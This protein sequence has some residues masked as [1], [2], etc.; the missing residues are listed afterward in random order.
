MSLKEKLDAIAAGFAA[1]VEPTVMATMKRA[2]QQ[3]F[4]SGILEDTVIP[5][6]RAPEF[7]L[8]DADGLEFSSLKMHANGPLVINFFRGIW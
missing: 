3:L 1:Q 4:E 2:S 7:S 6:D 5:G 8:S